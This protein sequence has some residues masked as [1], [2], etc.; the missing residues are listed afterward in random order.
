M[1]FLCWLLASLSTLGSLFFS[2]VMKYP[3]C[4]LCWYQR[5]CIYP[6]VLIFS[7]ALFSPDRK[8]FK[9]SFP[10]TLVGWSIAL[11]H[12]LLYY[13]IL[14]EKISPCT[15]GVSCVTEFINWFGFITIP[16]LS[17]ICFSLILIFL[18]L[19]FYGDLSHEK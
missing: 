17:F 8:V 15:Q 5:I 9:Y 12:N 4:V 3:P 14:P 7:A 6:L 13:K 16:L 11:Y 2:E 18:I 1:I 10:L 19:D